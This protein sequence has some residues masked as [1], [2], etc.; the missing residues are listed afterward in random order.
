PGTT[1][2]EGAGFVVLEPEDHARHRGKKPHAILSGCGLSAD[3]Y[4]ETSPDP[5]GSGLA[6]ALGAALSDAGLPPEAI[7]YINAHGSGTAANDQAEWRA[8]RSV[9]GDRAEQVPLSSTK[10]II[11]HAQGAAGVLETIV[12]VLGMQHGLV[13]QTL[14]FTDPRPFCPADPVAADR[15][16]PHRFTHAVNLSAGFGGS[17]AALVIS[18]PEA[19]PSAVPKRSRR[20]LS[21]IGLG[22]V[23]AFGTELDVLAEIVRGDAEISGETAD[24][25][26]EQLI[27]TAD[28]RGLDP[29]SRYLAAAAALALADGGVT[30][31]GDLR[32]RAGISSGSNRVSPSSKARFQRSLDTGGLA[33]LS[34]NGFARIVLNFPVSTAAKLLSLRGPAIALSSGSGSGLVSI[35]LA[36]QRLAIPGPTSLM[37]A[38]GVD[39]GESGSTKQLSGAACVLLS[40]VEPADRFREATPI[41]LAGWSLAGPGGLQLAVKRAL[42]MAEIEGQSLDRVYTDLE[43]HPIATSLQITSRIRF[44]DRSPDDAAHPSVLACAAA[45]LALRRGEIDSALVLSGAERSTGCAIVLVARR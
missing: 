12:T 17:N 29:A 35:V 1:L 32:E 39:E 2:G 26:L 6:R 31:R 19:L 22:A 10:S 18:A 37:I 34:A 4:H 13:P 8:V 33:R 28:T 20:Q 40:A 16:R 14:H 41:S 21:L 5:S 43:R 45:V 44:A 42:A 7:G 23:D 11:G 3:A 27:P 9:L 25:P 36:A 24:P 15:P 38:G 30:L